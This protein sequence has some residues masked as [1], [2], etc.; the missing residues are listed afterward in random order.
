[1]YS[2]ANF[3]LDQWACTGTWGLGQGT[4]QVE[5]YAGTHRRS[6]KCVV[7]ETLLYVCVRVC[8]EHQNELVVK[9]GTCG[10]VK[11]AWDPSRDAELREGLCHCS[12][13]S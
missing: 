7:H 2:P 6:C 12:E 4:R 8:R 9:W 11:A 3:K 1:M 10:V 13:D 5:F